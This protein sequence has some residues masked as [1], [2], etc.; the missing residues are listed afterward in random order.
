M[1][2]HD[3]RQ[4]VHKCYSLSVR[5]IHV[6]SVCM[7]IQRCY[8]VNECTVILL[9]QCSTQINEYFAIMTGKRCIHFA[10]FYQFS[11]QQELIYLMRFRGEASSYSYDV[12]KGNLKCIATISVSSKFLHK[13]VRR[14]A[15]M[16]KFQP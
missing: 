4:I 14:F 8:G 2:V 1:K 12:V 16:T 6:H 9:N 5:A 15:A 13:C 11:Y 3:Q 7:N 10:K